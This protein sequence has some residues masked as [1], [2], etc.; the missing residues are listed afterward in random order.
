MQ[1]TPITLRN[2]IFSRS[3]NRC[4][5]LLSFQQSHFDMPRGSAVCNAADRRD[6]A[7]S[8]GR[9][10]ILPQRRT[11]AGARAVK[12]PVG[13]L[14]V[15]KRCSTGRARWVLSSGIDPTFAAVSTRRGVHRHE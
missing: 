6:G 14:P 3:V 4:V 5:S 11:R 7:A 8:V 1:A 10:T 12:F 9:A 13:N 15:M 2:G